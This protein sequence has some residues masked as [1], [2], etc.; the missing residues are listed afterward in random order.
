MANEVV[1][2]F[3]G[4]PAR[5]I[6]ALEKIAKK[7]EAVAKKAKETGTA[8]EQA[9]RKAQDSAEKFS[10]SR[11]SAFGAGA[12]AQI[13]NYAMGVLSVSAAI[14]AVTKALQFMKEQSEEAGQAIKTIAEGRRQLLQ[15][16]DF[17]HEEYE[18]LEGLVEQARKTGMEP[19]EAYRTV[20]AA[21]SAGPEFATPEG[22]A[23]FAGLRE[24]GV[25][26]TEGVRAVVKMQQAFGGA[27]EGTEGAGDIGQALNKMLAASAKT[28]ATMEELARAIPQATAAFAAIGGQDE[29]LLALMSVL[30]QQ[31]KSPEMAA[32]RI[33]SLSQQ[34]QKK[35]G[36]IVGGEQLTAEQIIMNL[37]ELAAAGR[38]RDESGKKSVTMTKFLGEAGAIQAMQ[39]I[40]EQRGAIQARY[41]DIRMAERET[42]IGRDRQIAAMRLGREIAPIEAVRQQEMAAQRRLM[43]Q[44]ERL[45]AINQLA[46]AVRLERRQRIEAEELPHYTYTPGLGRI[47]VPQVGQIA[48]EEGLRFMRGDE[49][50]LRARQGTIQDPELARQVA[51]ALTRHAEITERNTAALEHNTAARTAETGNVGMRRMT[52]VRN[53]GL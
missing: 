44:A 11:E 10:K 2:Q 20:F 1:V 13:K 17:S 3:S 23:R 7:E 12:I 15:V 31:F 5:L 30:T 41:E 8:S 43:P 36:Q 32:E 39:A 26:P 45:G 22:I 33:A 48:Y 38:L 53:A 29:S 25:T 40:T 18:R 28:F 49:G 37:P 21:K 14:S 16:S 47:R 4:D 35:R 19:V 46:E 9:S 34:I 6:R 24:L 27:G 51:N 50:Y 42:G 52:P